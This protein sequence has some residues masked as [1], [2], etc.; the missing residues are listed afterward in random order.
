MARTY[1]TVLPVA[2]AESKIR[3]AQ[4]CH[5][6]TREDTIVEVTKEWVE[7]GGSYNPIIHPIKVQVW[8]SAMTKSNN[9]PVLAKKELTI[10][11]AKRNDLL[12]LFLY[13]F[14]MH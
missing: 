2:S 3:S 10:I 1:C 9:Q 14:I 6:L 8:M 5:T 11:P 12:F 4:D 13:A 7:R